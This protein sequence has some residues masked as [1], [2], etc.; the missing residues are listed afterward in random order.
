MQRGEAHRAGRLPLGKAPSAEAVATGQ[1]EAVEELAAEQ[2]DDRAQRVGQCGGDAVLQ[3]ILH[4]AK[5]DV[6]TTAFEG[7]PL[8]VRAQAD[9]AGI[10]K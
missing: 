2:A 10:I 1:V 7:D 6:G 8:P 4:C 9:R 3:Q 5:V